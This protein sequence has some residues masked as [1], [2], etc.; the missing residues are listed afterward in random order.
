MRFSRLIRLHDL[1]HLLIGDAQ[2][3]DL[4]GRL[5]VQTEIVND[6]LRLFVQLLG[7][8]LA[9]RAGRKPT[10]VDVFADGELEHDL[11]LLINHAD[12]G[13]DRLGRAVEV[14]RL[15]VDKI[16]AAGL[17]VVAVENFQKGRTCRRRSPPSG[18]RPRAICRKADVVESFHAGK[19]LGDVFE[20]NSVFHVPPPEKLI[21]ERRKP[22]RGERSAVNGFGQNAPEGTLPALS[23][24][25]L[26]IE[27]FSGNAQDKIPC[28]L[29]TLFCNTRPVFLMNFTKNAAYHW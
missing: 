24:S 12:A 26:I 14:A 13:G 20:L 5:D 10:E 3:L 29:R 15:T 23:F 8:D 6:F 17:L 18:L 2:V 4:V 21:A 22:R 27:F 1:D 7:F 9:E 28:K 16:L 11:A 25:V 19:V